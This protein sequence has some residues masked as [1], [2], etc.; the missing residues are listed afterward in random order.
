MT[1]AGKLLP[2]VCS[3]PLGLPVE[4][5]VYSRN[6]GCSD[7]TH[8][9]GACGQGIG[10][11][12]SVHQHIESISMLHMAR[13]GGRQLDFVAGPMQLLG[14]PGKLGRGPLQHHDSLQFQLQPGRCQNHAAPQQQHQKS[15]VGVH[16]VAKKPPHIA[17]A[18]TV[19]SRYSA[20]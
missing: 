1:R 17:H 2:V 12:R 20:G 5:E 16:L 19:R 9:T 15:W 4:P 3:T 7:S 6:R 11:R 14:D 8:S 10:H 13:A 18:C